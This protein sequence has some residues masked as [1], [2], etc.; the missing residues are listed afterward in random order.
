MTLRRGFA[1]RSRDLG[2]QQTQQD[3]V[4]IRG[5][6]R[7]VHPQERRARGLFAA[8]SQGTVSQPIHKPLEPNGHLDQL[9]P[10]A[11]SHP[12]DET[13]RHQRLPNCHLGAP[14]W[15]VLEQVVDGHGQVVVGV[16]EPAI[17]GDDPVPVSIR[18]VP[19]A[20]IVVAS[21]LNE[22]RHGVRR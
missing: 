18:I 5:P 10:Q 21:R 11:L 9:P 16:H 6:R 14:T 8:E 15:T 17:R 4:L 2:S 22:R 19:K 1:G 12:V 3:P 7:A 13:G 20:Q